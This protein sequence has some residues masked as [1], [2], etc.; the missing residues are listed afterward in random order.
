[1]SKRTAPGSGLMVVRKVFHL[2]C[3]HW[4]PNVPEGHKCGQM[5]GHTYRV[6]VDV[7]GGLD[8]DAG[9]V[10]DFAVISDAWKTNVHAVLDHSILND[11][12]DNPT[13]EHLAMWI[14]GH[15][16][17]GFPVARIAVWETATSCAILKG[18][19]S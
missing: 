3:A 4:L 19:C 10:I 17:G 2:E 9:W 12:M 8:V 15:L 5:H 1:L 13:A 6:E 7:E 18:I 14:L 11:H 16:K